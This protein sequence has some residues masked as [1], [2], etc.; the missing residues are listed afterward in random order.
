MPAPKAEL[1]EVDLS[2]IRKITPH[3][4]WSLALRS[5]L[6]IAV[7]AQ[8]NFVLQKIKRTFAAV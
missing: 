6:H 7:Q 8:K 5:Y 2:A 1:R 4:L 3:T